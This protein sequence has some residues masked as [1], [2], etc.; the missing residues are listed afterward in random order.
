MK[1]LAEQ[2][3][4]GLSPYLAHLALR[5]SKERCQRCGDR[6]EQTLDRSVESITTYHKSTYVDEEGTKHRRVKDCFFPL[7]D[8]KPSSPRYLCSACKWQSGKQQ[9]EEA[10]LKKHRMATLEEKLLPEPRLSLTRPENI[11]ATNGRKGGRS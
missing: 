7:A 9:R 2:Q 10:I 6:R 11:F 8:A 5:P 4:E 3:E 1:T